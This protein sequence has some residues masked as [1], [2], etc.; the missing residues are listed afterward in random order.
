MPIS[1]SR[2]RG[3]CRYDI[4]IDETEAPT[5]RTRF[6]ARV[7]NAVRTDS[8]QAVHPGPACPDADGA[9]RGEAALNIEAAMEQW[10]TAQTGEVKTFRRQSFVE[11]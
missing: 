11:L 5:K 9:R 1:Y 2:H 10:V 8:G 6:R 7:L 4:E 3:I